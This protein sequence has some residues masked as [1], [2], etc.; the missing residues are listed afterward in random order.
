[1]D[2]T[3][4]QTADEL[5]GD[6]KSVQGQSSKFDEISASIDVLSAGN[7]KVKKFYSS[8]ILFYR[9]SQINSR[10]KG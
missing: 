4:T 7:A 3:L 9:M 8:K 6:I 5:R 1:M 2:S 10:F